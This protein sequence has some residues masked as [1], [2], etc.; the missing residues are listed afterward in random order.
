MMNTDVSSLNH[1]VTETKE[2][3]DDLVAAGPFEV[4][5]QAYSH[6][7]AVLHSLRDRLTVEEAVHFAAQLPMLIRGFYYEGWR[8]ALA[9]NEETT[10]GEFFA[11]V[12]ESLNDQLTGD[13]E[14]RESTEAVLKLLVNRVQ[15]GQIRHV[16]AQLPEELQELW[17]DAPT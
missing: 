8:P 5:Q 12:R 16:R 6:L 9:P 13:E 7:R 11:S 4:E 15:P 1:T 17:S 14:L 3:L 10:P 2:W